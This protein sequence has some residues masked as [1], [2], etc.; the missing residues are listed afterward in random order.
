[1]CKVE[2]SHNHTINNTYEWFDGDDCYD[3]D[4]WYQD[5]YNVSVDNDM[6][7]N[8]DYHGE[9]YYKELKYIFDPRIVYDMEVIEEKIL[10]NRYS[11]GILKSNIS[12][13]WDQI[14]IDKTNYMKYL[15]ELKNITNEH[16]DYL[17]QQDQLIID[18]E[19]NYDVM[20]CLLFKNYEFL[21]MHV[22]TQRYRIDFIKNHINTK[23]V[24]YKIN[25][26][27]L[28]SLIKHY[29]VKLSDNSNWI[30]TL[31][32]YVEKKDDEFYSLKNIEYHNNNTNFLPN[33]G[34]G[35][36]FD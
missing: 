14:T 21:S 33:S 13:L 10:F 15:D 24:E 28:N 7:T 12:Y 34:W 3:T 4:Q 11:V 23:I 17:R 9:L 2:T 32:K 25:C 26:G 16:N 30:Q 8:N 29:R 35:D 22:D 5:S 36:G 19:N 31:L 20:T 1:V 27:R 18:I 6:L